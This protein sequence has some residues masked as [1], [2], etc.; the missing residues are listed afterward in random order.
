MP[1]RIPPSPR[2]T[3]SLFSTP[4]PNGARVSPNVAQIT[5]AEHEQRVVEIVGPFNR[6]IVQQTARGNQFE[7]ENATLHEKV[8][9]LE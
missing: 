1:A 6:S 8:K 4:Q 2:V 7:I 3:S 9:R 5:L